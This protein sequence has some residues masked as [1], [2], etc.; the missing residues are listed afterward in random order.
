MDRRDL[1][2]GLG[3]AAALTLFPDDVR[4]AWTRAAIPIRPLDGFTD[5]QLAV[6]ATIADV[7]I[8]RT[9]TP[10]ALDVR[11]PAFIDALVAESWPEADRTTFR[12]GL[13][14]LQDRVSQAGGGS[15]TGMI[16]DIERQSDRRIEPQRTYWQLKSLIVH[17]YFTSEVVSKDVLRVEIMPG[18]F[19]GAA[20]LTLRGT[21]RS[22]SGASHA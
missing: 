16:D 3:A 22:E 7:I 17:G 18:S 12:A 15:L 6:V 5:A 20:P 21:R 2:R 14:L 4:A 10:G 19:N 11:V 9:D 8:P 1:L 13:D